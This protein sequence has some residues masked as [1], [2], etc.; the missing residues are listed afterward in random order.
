MIF[1][2]DLG[3]SNGCNFSAM[4][5]SLDNSYRMNNVEILAI[6]T[7]ALF[8]SR[9]I[10]AIWARM[11]AFSL[12]YTMGLPMILISSLIVLFALSEVDRYRW[13]ILN[14]LT[15]GPLCY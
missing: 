13:I 5:G 4:A 9:A 7:K 10:A 11:S 1:Q 8:S 12:L 3:I 15:L 6:N 14:R 2:M